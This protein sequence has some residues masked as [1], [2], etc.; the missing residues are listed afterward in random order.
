[1]KRRIKQHSVYDSDNINYSKRQSYHVHHQT[2]LDI[3]AIGEKPQVS[4]GL[5]GL[6]HPMRLSNQ[7]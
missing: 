1:M 7:D 2:S 6:K 5:Q 3:D 4:G